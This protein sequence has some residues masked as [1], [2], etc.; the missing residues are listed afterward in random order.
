MLHS[1]YIE[2]E[3]Y[4]PKNTNDNPHVFSKVIKHIY[5]NCDFYIIQK[6]L[7][8]EKDFQR[9]EYD[10]TEIE[11]LQIRQMFIQGKERFTL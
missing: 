10:L 3:I 7:I 11:N 5:R 4:Y 8:I 2:L 9:H 6:S 1:Y